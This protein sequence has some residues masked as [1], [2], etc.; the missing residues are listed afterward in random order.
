MDQDKIDQIKKLFGKI[1]ENEPLKKHTSLKVGGPARLFFEAHDSQSLGAI[2]KKALDLKIPYL[3]IGN[4]TN[5]VFAD[6]GLD[7]LV[8]K[9]LSS[10]I[11]FESHEAIV[12]SGMPLARMINILAES[13]LGGLEFLAG[14]PGSLGGAI[15]GNAGAYGRTMADITRGIILMDIDGKKIQISNEDMKF[16]YRSSYLKEVAQIHNRFKMPV[17]LAARLKI[18]PKSKEGVLRVVSNYLKIRASKQPEFPSAGSFFKNIYI[19]IDTPLNK[20][21]KMFVAEGKIPAGLLIEKAGCKGLKVG[22]AMVSPVHANYLVNSGRA[23]AKDFQ[24]LARKVEEKIK[25]VFNLDLQEEVEFIGDFDVKPK[26]FLE[27]IFKK[28]R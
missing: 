24:I 8:V 23:R 22:G 10:K 16:Q 9:N 2:T 20:E 21:T 17:I 18:T 26:T 11:V 19:T 7:A 25:D 3:I 12:D 6:S 5:I 14:I 28:K 4:G 1:K 15:Y 13:N 27:K